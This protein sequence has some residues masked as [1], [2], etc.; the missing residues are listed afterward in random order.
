MPNP[1]KPKVVGDI[2]SFKITAVRDNFS[3]LPERINLS[4]HRILR[5]PLTKLLRA[6]ICVLAVATLVL[7]SVTAP[8]GLPTAAG[9]STDTERK[10]LE[11]QLAQLEGQIN[12]YED[13][14]SGYQKQGSS[15]KGEISL[16][17]N[18]IAK[19]NLQ[20]QAIN[21]T[22]KD[23]NNKI[24][25]TQS[26]ITDTES[27]IADRRAALSKLF[28]NLYESEQVSLMEVFL[29]NPQLSDFF[30]DVNSLTLL[31]NDLRVTVQQMTDLRNQLQDQQ[32]QFALAKSDAE[33]VQ[34]YQVSQ[35]T[36]IDNTK[37]EKNQLLTVT[38]GQESKYQTLLQQT[39][40]TAAQIRNRIFQ[41]LGGGELSFEQAYEYAKLA[42]GATGIAPSLILAILDRE[43]ALGQNVGKCS[44]KTA[45]SPSNQTIFL[46]LT[47]ELNIDPNSVT[48]SCPNKDGT[49]GGAMGPAQFIPSTWNLYTNA[50]SKV[51]GHS[52]A[53]PWNNADAFAATALYLKD[54]MTGCAAV[55]SSEISRERCV[56]AKYYAGGRWQSYLW[57]Y[58]EAV[59]N[60]AQ[61]FADD[62]KTINS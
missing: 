59:V 5:L 44:Y 21:L 48:V 40:A 41:L 3:S 6:A 23:L 34:A 54:A 42:S 14:V 30:G 17:N 16:L 62:I 45:M 12:Q 33:S 31:Q 26:Q 60:R 27:S 25:E 38:K 10:A 35:K 43:S 52:P 4:Y 18:K 57:T 24:S 36:V 2:N 1:P 19:L 51:T 39:K 55:Y 13:Q 53:S 7:G 56:A 9:Q 47:A 61:S 32:Q 8:T 28:Q 58:G 11:D 15:L 49:Y 46:Q 37:A 22:L 29:K 20:I 50:V